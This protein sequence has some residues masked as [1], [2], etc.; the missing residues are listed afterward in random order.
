[1]KNFTIRLA[2]DT[3][4]ERI[5]RLA[6]LDSKR[7]PH[8]DVVVAEVNGRLLAAMGMDGTVVADP[9]ERTGAAVRVLRP[10]S[11]ASRRAAGGA[12]RWLAPPGG[13]PVALSA[14]GYLGGRDGARSDWMT[15]PGVGA[16]RGRVG[17]LGRARTCSSSSRSTIWRRASWRGRAWRSPRWCC[18]RSRGAA[19]PC[20]ACR[21]AG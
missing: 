1:M 14:D 9:F 15:P 11:P 3:D 18:C 13:I 6:E 10:S 2:T 17:G 16:V 4:L 12:G 21:C 5:N 8:G 7:P 20:A 19:A